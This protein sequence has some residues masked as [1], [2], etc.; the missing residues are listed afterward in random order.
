MADGLGPWIFLCIYSFST[1]LVFGVQEI[2]KSWILPPL[3]LFVYIQIAIVW[4]EA[5]FVL[6]TQFNSVNSKPAAAPETPPLSVVTQ[7]RRSLL[8]FLLYKSWGLKPKVS[9]YSVATVTNEIIEMEQFF[10]KD[11]FLRIEITKL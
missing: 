10:V 6:C 4:R 11:K 5:V 2:R 3:C 1:L 9:F 7:T 8:V